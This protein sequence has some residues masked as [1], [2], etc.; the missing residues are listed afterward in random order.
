MHDASS[1]PSIQEIDRATIAGVVRAA[2]GNQAEL[3]DWHIESINPGMGAATGAMYRVTGSALVD[4][5]A[6]PWSS[7]LK[8]LNL[9]ASSTNPAS[10]A[11]D[12]P[13]YWEREALAYQSG[14][15]EDLPGGL[16][17]PRC[18]AVTRRADNALW[19]W[20]DEA[21][22]HHGSRWPLNQYA[23]AARCLGRFNGAYLAGRPMPAY[24]W[25]CGPASLRGMLD[26]FAGFEDVIRDPQ[27]W[28]QPL[29]QRAIPASAAP[30]LLRLWAERAPLIDALER[31]PQTLCHKDAWRRNMFANMSDSDALV[32]IDWA[33]VGR[34]ELGVDAG[35][36]FAASYSLFG[37]EPC[38]PREL[39][40]VVFG[41][42]LTGLRAAGW[43]GDWRLARFGYAAYA[44]L[45]YGCLTFWLRDAGDP[46]SH[47]A[48]ERLAG[49]PMADY[50]ENQG[51]LVAYLLDLADEARGLIA[52]VSS[53]R[54]ARSSKHTANC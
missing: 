53:R 30:R 46:P 31:V 29:V 19:L 18:L 48:W 33:Y 54:S 51:R 2:L 25:L 7:I 35:D 49:Y 24:S 50:V 8:V 27:A 12:H 41:H 9:T 5:Q 21:R 34:G 39:D 52:T 47:T 10:R 16:T 45:K 40:Q 28:Q 38:E 4:R 37:V 17:A 36:L 13:L 3:T 26:H 11:I 42:Y 1:D 20:L 43:Q 14:L 32:M 44:A 22:E 23:R 6:V 15:L